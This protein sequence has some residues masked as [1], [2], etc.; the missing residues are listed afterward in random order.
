MYSGKGKFA[1]FDRSYSEVHGAPDAVGIN[2]GRD[3][4]DSFLI[5]PIAHDVFVADLSNHH[6]GYSFLHYLHLDGTGHS[7]EWGSAAWYATVQFIDASLGAIMRTIE[8]D[9]KLAGD[10]VIILTADHGGTGTGHGIADDRKNYTIPVL[11]W[12]R[13]VTAGADLYDLNL[14]SRFDPGTARPEYGVALPPIRNG[15]TGNLALSLLGLGAVPGSTINANQDL[16]VQFIPEPSAIFLGIFGLVLI[17]L[18][19]SEYF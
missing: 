8:N 18:G 10:T 9:A 11:V 16:M 1:L 4:I 7:A 15:D 19:R 3:K 17:S 12:G 6:Y 5:H 13:G 2:N 14:L